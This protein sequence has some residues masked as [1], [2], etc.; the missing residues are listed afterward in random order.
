MGEHVGGGIARSTTG[1][2][3]HRPPLRPPVHGG[4]RD[5]GPRVSPGRG[6]TGEPGAGSHGAAREG[7][8][9]GIPG[10]GATGEPGTGAR[11][12]PGRGTTGYPA[13]RGNGGARGG[14]PQGRP[15]GRAAG[16]LGRVCTM[17]P[18]FG[19]SNS[20][21]P[22]SILPCHPPSGGHSP[23]HPPHRG[24]HRMCLAAGLPSALS[25]PPVAWGHSIGAPIV[26]V[27]Y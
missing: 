21:H 25:H 12:S 26:A 7:G 8:P 23:L 20:A 16:W 3:D 24:R 19:C 14:K 11:G 2:S 17:P 27:N 6:A 5:G 4:A 15:G 9:R 1:R 13:K 22:P 18:P 10:R